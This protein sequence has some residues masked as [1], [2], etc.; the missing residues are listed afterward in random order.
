MLEG[1]GRCVIMDV[2]KG[3]LED[4]LEGVLEGVLEELEVGNAPIRVSIQFDED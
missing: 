3:A 2:L 1:V 4:A